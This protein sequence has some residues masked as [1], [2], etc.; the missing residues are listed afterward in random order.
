MTTD[1]SPYP[2]WRI[3]MLKA[4]LSLLGSAALLAAGSSHAATILID[5]DDGVANG[6]HEAAV[7]NGG[8]ESTP[9]NVNTPN[10][11][12]WVPLLEPVIQISPN[13]PS[14]VG[15]NNAVAGGDANQDLSFGR[16]TGHTLALG[17]SFTAEYDWRDA[18]GW[19]P[20]ETIGLI[21]FYTANNL[22]DGTRTTLFTFNSGSEENNN[23]WETESFGPTAPLADAG[24]AGKT[25]FVA[26]EGANLSGDA[27]ARIDNVF[28]QVVP[29][30]GSL[31]LVALG[32][33]LMLR[34][35][36]S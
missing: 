3:A 29:E 10:A 35:R 14:P 30:P 27:F 15:G 12:G 33:I 5:Y 11:D 2:Y 36:R 20:G 19:N 1:R 17:D 23:Q 18:F 34:Q 22:I 24:A 9:G 13:L 8:F 31:A 16:S 25:L 28:L 6:I 4:P 21:L 7:S 32:S 26:F